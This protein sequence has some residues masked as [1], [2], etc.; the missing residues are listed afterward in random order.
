MNEKREFHT[1]VRRIGV[2]ACSAHTL[3]HEEKLLGRR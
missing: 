1:K 2:K 3:T